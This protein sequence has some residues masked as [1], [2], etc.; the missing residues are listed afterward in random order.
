MEFSIYENCEYLQPVT[1]SD[2]SLRPVL[3]KNKLKE[4]LVQVIDLTKNYARNVSTQTSDHVTPTAD[5]SI[6][7]ENGY[8]SYDPTVNIPSQN[9]VTVECQ[10]ECNPCE[11]ETLT[12][13]SVLQPMPNK[14]RNSFKKRS[15]AAR[16][17]DENI[18]QQ[19][20]R[21]ILSKVNDSYQLFPFMLIITIVFLCLKFF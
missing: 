19:I 5:T 12:N 20:L 11:E 18:V 10:T 4:P 9:C 21:R 17:D 1:R 16:A 8:E 7:I 13:S 3:Q 14:N 6:K 15:Y 2:K